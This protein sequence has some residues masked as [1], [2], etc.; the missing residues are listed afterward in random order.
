MGALGKIL[1][2][3]AAAILGGVLNKP[4]APKVPMAAPVAQTRASSAVLDAVASRQGSLANR[5][6]GTRGAEAG[7]GS[8]TSLGA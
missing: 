6:T 8:K 2:S 7:G 4:K 1:L 5:R 3:P